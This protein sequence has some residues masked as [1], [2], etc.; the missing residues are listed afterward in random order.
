[1]EGNYRLIVE[2]EHRKTREGN[3]VPY[4]CRLTFLATVHKLTGVHALRRYE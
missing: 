3:Q 2:L 1:M 4:V